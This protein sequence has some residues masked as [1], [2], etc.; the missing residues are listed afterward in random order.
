MSV[1]LHD[2]IEILH[3]I[4]GSKGSGQCASKTEALTPAAIASSVCALS[5]SREAAHRKL[6]SP[7]SLD[8]Y[9][10]EDE[11]CRSGVL[12]TLLD[13]QHCRLATLGVHFDV[14]PSVR[15]TLPD[16]LPSC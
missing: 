12:P 8:R 3:R 5:G 1:G 7:G 16:R 15:T 10:P 2:P 4:G 13:S 14:G 9:G 11:A 6:E